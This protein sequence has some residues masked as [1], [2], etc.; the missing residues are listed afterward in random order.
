MI[1]KFETYNSYPKVGDWIICKID[2]NTIE[3]PN[4]QQL[5]NFFDNNIGKV[6]G[7]VNPTNNYVSVRYFPIIEKYKETYRYFKRKTMGEND[8]YINMN[9]NEIL[10]FSPNKDDIEVYVQTTKYN[11]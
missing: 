11:I 6:V 5:R 7:P 9:N 4:R 8:D 10:H 3:A 2:E 1:K